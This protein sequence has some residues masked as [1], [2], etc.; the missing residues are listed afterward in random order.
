M[1]MD[2]DMGDAHEV[3]GGDGDGDG[4][5]GTKPRTSREETACFLLPIE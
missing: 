3:S 1:Q 2:K 4:W 5:S